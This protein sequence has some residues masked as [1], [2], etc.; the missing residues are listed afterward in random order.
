MAALSTLA[1]LLEQT[2]VELTAAGLAA[3]L[4]YEGV[5]PGQDVA[6]DFGDDCAGML[7][8]RLQS[9]FASSA[10]FPNADFVAQRPG[11]PLRLAHVFEIGLVRG[12]ELPDNAAPAEPVADYADV[13]RQL[14]EQAAIFRAICSYF[15][16]LRFVDWLP[17]SYVPVGPQGAVLGGVWTVTA[18]F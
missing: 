8:T 12:V 6:Y 7:W 10:I 17:G 11:V 16:P 14:A 5:K 18:R 13:E 1:G 3:G 15:K 4:C 9:T 2:K